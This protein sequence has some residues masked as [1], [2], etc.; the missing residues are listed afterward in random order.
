MEKKKEKKTTKWVQ[1]NLKLEDS[2]QFEKE[3]KSALKQTV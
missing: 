2:V 3:L 1:K